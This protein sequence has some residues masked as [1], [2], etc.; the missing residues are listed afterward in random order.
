MLSF[1]C[2]IGR[3]MYNR[4]LSAYTEQINPDRKYSMAL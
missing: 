1:I 3:Y 2:M 4:R